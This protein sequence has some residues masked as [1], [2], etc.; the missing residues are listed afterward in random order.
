MFAL[1]V[2]DAVYEEGITVSE[3]EVALQAGVRRLGG[4]APRGPPL[5]P[6]RPQSSQLLQPRSANRLLEG[7]ASAM[8]GEGP[9]TLLQERSKTVS[10]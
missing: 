2:P 5:T 8:H 10:S 7:G 6:P 4:G 9:V 1:N 3:G